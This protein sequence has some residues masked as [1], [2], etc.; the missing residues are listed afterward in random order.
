MIGAFRIEAYVIVSADGMIADATGVQPESLHFEA[1]QRH[2]QGGLDRA[3]VRGERTP[4][5]GSAAGFGEPAA[6]RPHSAGRG[7]RA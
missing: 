6:A 1:D 5:G 7:A 2:F 3:D 4:F